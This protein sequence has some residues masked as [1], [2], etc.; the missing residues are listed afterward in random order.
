MAA[1]QA[2]AHEGGTRR[3]REAEI[4]GADLA[5]FSVAEMLVKGRQGTNPCSAEGNQVQP[6]EPLEIIRQQHA[7]GDVKLLE[8][9][10]LTLLVRAI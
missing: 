2:L 8:P 5:E 9:N 3:A 7:E 6:S 4:S 1:A 10:L